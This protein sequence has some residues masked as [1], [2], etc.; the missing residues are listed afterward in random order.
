MLQVNTRVA[1]AACE[2]LA[3]RAA[4]SAPVDGHEA[5]HDHGSSRQQMPDQGGSQDDRSSPLDCCQAMTSCGTVIDLGPVAEPSPR[6]VATAL[7]IGALA[8]TPL[9]RITAPEPPPPK[10]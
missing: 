2:S 1:F 10:A 7:A 9:S 6:G 5:G 4:A 8:E 3:S